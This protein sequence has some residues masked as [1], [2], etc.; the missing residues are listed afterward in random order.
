MNPPTVLD[1]FMGLI[2]LGPKIDLDELFSDDAGGDR[3]SISIQK[4]DQDQNNTPKKGWIWHFYLAIGSALS[5]QIF[6]EPIYRNEIVAVCL[7]SI[8]FFFL[9]KGLLRQT[10]KVPN[11]EIIRKWEPLNLKVGYFL[12][13]LGLLIWAFIEFDEGVFNNANL[14][15][16]ISGVF[17]YLLS[18]LKKRKPFE[19][20]AIEKRHDWLFTGLG[21]L[22]FAIALF[23]RFY[24]LDNIPKE[25]F[26]DHAEKL[27]DIQDVLDGIY[28]VF[29]ARNTGREAIQFYLTAGII[30]FFKSGIN[31]LSL[32]FGMAVVGLLTLPSTYLLGRQLGGKWVGILSVFF[33]AIGY[34]PNVI[35]RVGLRYALYPFFTVTSLFF[36][37]K[38][39]QEKNKNDLVIAGLWIG[40]G[41]HGYS[42]FRIVPVL[43]GI[44]Y[45]IYA[46]GEKNRGSF[47]NEFYNFVL[48][49][50][51]AVII[52]IP[53]FRY[54]LDN[55]NNFSYRAMTRLTG[56]EQA[57]SDPL[58]IVFVNNLF[59]AIIMFFYSNGV[60]WVHSIP[61]RP[62]LDVV[63]AAF[64]FIGTIY[65]LVR[66]IRYRKWEDVVL[67]IS[68]P[69]LMM[70]SIL[71][72]AFPGENPSLN[73]TSGAYPMIY[74]VVSVGFYQAVKFI[75]VHLSSSRSKQIAIM[76]FLGLLGV[77]AVQNYD[78]VFN[79]YSN[80][81][82][83][84][85]W[86]TSEIGS[87]INKFW[88]EGYTP[89]NTVVVPYP[90]WVDTRLVGICAGKPRVDFALWPEDFESLQQ[91]QGK[92]LIVL[93]P[94][95]DQSLMALKQLFP[96]NQISRYY[97][98]TQGKDF[99]IFRTSN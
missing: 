94:E 56:V 39:F 90:H 34:W 87:V 72:L 16:W 7:Y 18:V 10:E 79:Q 54:A 37:I 3:H 93:K 53:L 51:S 20:A 30:K 58:S 17:F 35:S 82:A 95:D 70:P 45:L 86:N 98:N 28:P 1:Y 92:K 33:A 97:S 71:S 74:I 42:P 46:A 36:L 91:K 52:T 41:L 12:I 9:W 88:D 84:N 38:G 23:F 32:K 61:G 69:I 57:I 77:A 89:G 67:L 83:G 8:S 65:L 27:L 63:T 43:V 11:L 47:H 76:V 48:I 22:V 14:F 15:L 25:M 24:Q 2:H 85:A 44:I 73:R 55:P 5:A 26:S 80:Q 49:A 21:I 75:L 40:A 66:F 78:L 96:V 19:K 64:Y 13:A 6:L 29:F 81:Y 99:L 4:S 50:F 59:K 68:I 62:A 31:F 60:I